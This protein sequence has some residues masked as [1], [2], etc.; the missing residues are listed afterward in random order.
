MDSDRRQAM[1]IHIII[2]FN[3][4]VT[5]FSTETTYLRKYNM[6][7]QLQNHNVLIRII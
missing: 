5:W 6:I 2:F 4:E 3:L 7:A 1:Q